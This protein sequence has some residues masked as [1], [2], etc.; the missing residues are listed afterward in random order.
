MQ[1]SYVDYSVYLE[2][3]CT[4]QV[5]VAFL[6]RCVSEVSEDVFFVVVFSSVCNYN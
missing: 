6:N 1:V 3:G 5:S 4:P 2:L